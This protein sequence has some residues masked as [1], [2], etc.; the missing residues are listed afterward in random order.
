MLYRYRSSSD[1]D[2]ERQSDAQTEER[3]NK[4]LQEEEQGKVIPR[5]QAR[6]V[7]IRT[8]REAKTAAA[9][10]EIPVTLKVRMETGRK[11]RQSKTRNR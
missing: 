8:R 4:P 1:S 5:T 10:K 3:K 6:T 7:Q 9:V 2:A 11:E